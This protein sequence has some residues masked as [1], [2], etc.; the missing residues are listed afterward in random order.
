[1]QSAIT[2]L[3]EWAGHQAVLVFGRGLDRTQGVAL[4]QP[5]SLHTTMTGMHV[6]FPGKVTCM[7][8]R[9]P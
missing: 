4:A 2:P 9:R 7:R 6:Y 3:R 8:H 1:M 5:P